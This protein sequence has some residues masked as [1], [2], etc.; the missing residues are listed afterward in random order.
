MAEDKGAEKK[1]KKT[2]IR[3]DSKSTTKTHSDLNHPETG[4]TKVGTKF[5]KS[6]PSGISPE[7]W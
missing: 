7:Q 5:G 1:R 2:K 6:H 3:T 4:N